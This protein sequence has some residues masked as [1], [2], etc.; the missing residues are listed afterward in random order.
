MSHRE[1]V[2]CPHCGRI[3]EAVL[4]DGEELK[5][6]V[7]PSDFFGTPIHNFFRA[8]GGEEIRHETHCPHCGGY[9]GM[10]TLFRH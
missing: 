6:A 5:A 9:V 2:Q 1:E 10:K 8:L 7:S 3:F 4:P